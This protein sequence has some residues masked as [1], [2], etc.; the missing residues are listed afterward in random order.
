MASSFLSSLVS[1][2]AR[3][4]SL[5]PTTSLNSPIWTTSVRFFRYHSD[6]IAK[7]KVPRRFG[8]EEK[9]LMKGP[10]PRES[11]PDLP[12]KTMPEYL[13][14]NA[15]NEKRALFG[16]ND[17]KI[18]HFRCH[19]K[20][21]L[22]LFSCFTDIDILGPI[23]PITTKAIHPTQLLYNLPPWLRGVSG[24]EYQVLLRKRKIL[25]QVYL[26]HS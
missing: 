24:N 8:Y 15:W 14:K 2:A 19:F 18:S 21:F 26:N 4:T 5:L 7:G 12:I 10:L 16:Q 6:K 20:L 17:C 11:F 23:N 9:M 25:A 13:P 22:N 3:S 1:M